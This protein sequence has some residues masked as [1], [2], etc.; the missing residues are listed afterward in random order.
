M[1]HKGK[2][3]S[4]SVDNRLSPTAVT[5]SQQERQ[6]TA[7]ELASHPNSCIKLSPCCWRLGRAITTPRASLSP[8][9]GWGAAPWGYTYF[10][11]IQFHLGVVLRQS[12]C[13]GNVTR[14][15]LFSLIITSFSLIVFWGLGSWCSP[16]KLELKHTQ[17]LGG[18][19]TMLSDMQIGM[20]G[21]TR[22]GKSKAQK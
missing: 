14:S 9:F 18:K 7:Q 12:R 15:H 19:Y 11:Q 2:R 5:V 16:H 17:A 10:L 3:K 22:P 1:S 13:Q 20:W 4:C 6:A 8:C 21:G